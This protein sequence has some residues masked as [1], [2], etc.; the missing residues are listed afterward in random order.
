MNGS[1]VECVACRYP[2]GR[3]IFGPGQQKQKLNPKKG[4]ESTQRVVF[5]FNEDLHGPK[6]ENFLSVNAANQQEEES[7]Y[8]LTRNRAQRSQ[9]KEN[10]IYD[11][12]Q[13]K[14]TTACT[15]PDFGT[16]GFPTHSLLAYSSL[17]LRVRAHPLSLPCEHMRTNAQSIQRTRLLIKVKGWGVNG[18]GHASNRTLLVERPEEG[19]GIS[20]ELDL[21]ELYR[22]GSVL[23]SETERKFQVRNIDGRQ[24]NNGKPQADSEA[25]SQVVKY[26]ERRLPVQ[27]SRLRRGRFEIE[28]TNIIDLQRMS[29]RYMRSAVPAG[30]EMWTYLGWKKKD[31]SQ[32]L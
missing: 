25:E 11:V 12:N 9:A 28:N 2:G 23:H 3:W 4:R 13:S 8:T 31:G 20:W 24:K 21:E 22:I 1:R 30:R 10:F 6:S 27:N 14:L 29:H 26:E 16:P 15:Q 17:I 19:K 32:S 18:G 5:C 7:N